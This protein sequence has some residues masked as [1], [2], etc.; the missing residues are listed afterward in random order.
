MTCKRW[1]GLWAATALLAVPNV[2]SAGGLGSAGVADAQ[3]RQHA[4]A[5][6]IWCPTLEAWIPD[7]LFA[8]M[9]CSETNVARPAV[10]NNRITN[11]SGLLGLF[12]PHE[13]IGLTVNDDDDG[14][15]RTNQTDDEPTTDPDPET[16]PPVME[17]EP[18]EKPKGKDKRHKDRKKDRKKKDRSHKDKDRG[19]RK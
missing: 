7:E 2:G 16:D 19:K 3:V 8:Q 11:R 15:P 4:A 6:G 12:G 10:A 14:A 1:T 18:K 13:R 17:E 9:D 5:E